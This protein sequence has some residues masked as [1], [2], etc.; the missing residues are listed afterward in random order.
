VQDV[1][2]GANPSGAYDFDGVDDFIIAPNVPHQTP[3]TV[4]AFTKG[5]GNSNRR[6]IIRQVNSGDEN[7]S[8]SLF[9]NSPEFEVS[10]NLNKATSVTVP[11]TEFTHL[12]L[13]IPD[14]TTQAVK[15]FVDGNE[16]VSFSFSTTYSTVN[17]DLFISTGINKRDFLNATVDDVRIYN[18]ALSASEINQIYTNTDPDQ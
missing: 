15:G 13:R 2:S 17:S 7:Y 4:M 12:A 3:L 11:Q 10:N 6:R 16:V 5:D 8:L 14:D 18:R 1:V 9:N